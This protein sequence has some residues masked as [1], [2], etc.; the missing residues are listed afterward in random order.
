MTKWPIDFKSIVYTDST[1]LALAN[2]LYCNYVVEII[3]ESVGHVG[4]EPTSLISHV[5]SVAADHQ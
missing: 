2:A 4:I 3:N 1:T 5:I